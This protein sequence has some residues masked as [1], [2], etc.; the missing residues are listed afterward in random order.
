MPVATGVSAGAAD[1]AEDSAAQEAAELDEL[2]PEGD[3][4]DEGTGD[5]VAYKRFK[6]VND[7]LKL[8]AK[9]LAEIKEEYGSLAAFKDF[10]ADLRRD[11]INDS[12]Q[13]RAFIART[14]VQGFTSQRKQTEDA[15]AREYHA[16]I[17]DGVKQETAYAAYVVD[18][19]AAENAFNSAFLAQRE[20]E[21]NRVSGGTLDARIANALKTSPLADPDTLRKLARV[22][23]TDLA[24]EA[25]RLHDKETK[26]RSDYAVDKAKQTGA[27]GAAQKT[28]TGATQTAGAGPPDALK[29]PKG[30]REWLN[31]KLAAAGK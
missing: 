4:Q 18:M 25:K 11:N 27:K 23:G 19:K 9:E 28:G 31:K 10:I 16:A 22:P 30:A 12:E 15:A 3:G 29:D 8:T 13:V 5:P 17:A 2:D 26:S 1:Q 6:Q 20:A 24:A 14:N 21:V 7:R